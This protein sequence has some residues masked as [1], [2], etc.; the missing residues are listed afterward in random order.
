MPLDHALG[1]G[2]A[3]EEIAAVLREDDA[4]AHRADVVPR[5]PDALH[6]R[7]DRGRRLDLDHEIHGAHVDAEL[8][9]ARRDDG[10]QHAPLEA[11]LDV[12]ADVLR[13]RAVVR[14]GDLLLGDLVERLREALGE[15]ARVHEDHR[16][17]MRADQLDEARVDRGPD[18]VRSRPLRRR[19]ALQL[20]GLREARHVLDGDLD[21]QIEVLVVARVDDR[22]GPRRGRRLRRVE[23]AEQARDLVERPLR[24]AQPDALE[25][26]LEGA[27]SLE[28]FEREEEVRAAL[29][30]DHRVDLVD[31]DGLD[32]LEDRAGP[33]RQQEVERL[34]RGDED[35][36]RVL[37]HPLALA[38]RRVARAHPDGRQPVL[39][40]G[41]L[42]HHADAV[43][44][45]PQ[46]PLDVDAERLE[47]RDVEHPHALFLG[48]RREHQPIDRDEERA[49]RLSGPGRREQQ[50]RVALDDRG[51]ALRLRQRRRLERGLEPPPGAA[52]RERE[53]IRHGARRMA[54]PPDSVVSGGF[55]YFVKR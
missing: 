49:Q 11:V 12:G 13:D 43:E 53:R 19:S 38:L 42:R 25:R 18:G 55:G 9:R 36:G 41:A 47:R 5:A 31:D 32:A 15:P 35:L 27:L 34:G 54:R 7:G 21:L 20:L 17:A 29:S 28:P 3:R 2:G 6:P 22:H 48:R 39:L 26:R 50:R 51:P 46:V 45:G 30:V 10:G 44:R 33:R 23:P 52:M 24:R 8:E 14:A 4:A 40:A 16:R 37:P 1:H